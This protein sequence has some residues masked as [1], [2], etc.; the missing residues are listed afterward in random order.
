V[1]A[2]PNTR[3]SNQSAEVTKPTPTTKPDTDLPDR[4]PNG[5]P[6]EKETFYINYRLGNVENIDALMR[7]ADVAVDMAH[8]DGLRCN[9]VTLLDNWMFSNG[10]TLQCNHFDYKYYIQDKGRGWQISIA[11]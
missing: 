11:D 4:T 8:E 9:S 1:P 5:I 7:L 10:W 6:V 2:P 3:D